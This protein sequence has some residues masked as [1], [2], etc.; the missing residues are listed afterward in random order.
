[1]PEL[2]KN[3]HFGRC[4]RCDAPVPAGTGTLTADGDV[5]CAAHSP[6]GARP[7]DRSG[8]AAEIA[9]GVRRRRGGAGKP[10]RKAPAK[11]Q[12]DLFGGATHR[13]GFTEEEG[14]VADQIGECELTPPGRKKTDDAT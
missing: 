7:V 2:R 6:E 10:G 3:R 5:Q 11:P 12:L 13:W 8:M 4:C 14:P 1:M 9:R